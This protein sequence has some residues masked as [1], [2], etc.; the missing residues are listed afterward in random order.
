M[1]DGA[2]F[3]VNLTGGLLVP[4]FQER[5]VAAQ[6]FQ[7]DDIVQSIIAQGADEIVAVLPSQEAGQ[8]V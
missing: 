1:N 7:L 8:Q 2:I 6:T 5:G 3:N 4:D